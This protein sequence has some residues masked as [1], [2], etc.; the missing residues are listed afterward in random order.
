MKKIL[1]I[2]GAGMTSSILVRKMREAAAENPDLDYKI[3]S[4][5]ASQVQQYASQA[6]VLLIAPHLAYLKDELEKSEPEKIVQIIPA[7]LYGSFETADVLKLVENENEKTVRKTWGQ[8]LLSLANRRILKAI[9]LAFSSAMPVL[10]IGG[11]FTILENLPLPRYLDL[12]EGTWIP[13]MLAIGRITT[14]GFIAVYMAFLVAYHYGQA[15]KVSGPHAG[16][17]S[18]IC[19]FLILDIQGGIMDLTYLGTKGIFCAFITA[20]LSVRSF[21]LFH[22]LSERFTRGLVNVPHAIY[23]S[24]FSLIPGFFSI[25]FFTVIA[26]LFKLTPYGSFS[27]FVY[28]FL[29]GKISGLMGEHIL[30]I[31]LA[32]L[33]THLFWFV[34]I[35]GGN[36][37]SSVTNPI[38]LPLALENVQAF[39]LRQPLPHIIH[40][41]FTSVCMFGGAGSTL[42]L[43]LLMCFAAKS[44]R[45]KQLGKLSL[46]M[47]IFFINEP[48]IFG[49]PIMMNPLMLVPFILVPV[50]S[51]LLTYIVMSAGIV[52]P[53]VGFEIP[54]TTPPIITGLIQ[55]GWVLMVWQVILFFFQ[56]AVWYPF[57]RIQDQKYLEEESVR[58]SAVTGGRTQ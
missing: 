13:E 17:N 20:Y 30:S 52:P 2:C 53:A 12:I 57:F 28:T 32:S 7:E 44:A 18:L 29:Q 5:S 51:I 6:D 15:L 43:V 49:F 45:L 34:G 9:S 50:S 55:G 40:S 22:G 48:V 8:R 33:L 47:G 3:G 42:P 36:L 37:V 1:V 25:V 56:T 21:K 23:N 16:V 31:L 10:I 14:V 11:V 54:W 58:H 35:H 19:F 39:S 24:F 41:K 38:L 27:D 46:P 4:C 26:A